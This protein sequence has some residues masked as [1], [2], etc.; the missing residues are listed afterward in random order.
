MKKSLILFCFA[1]ASCQSSTEIVSTQSPGVIMPL[2][3]GNIWA[4]QD[5][6]SDG[7]I[8]SSS[9]DTLELLNKFVLGSDTV[10]VS[11]VETYYANRKDGLWAQ[12]FGTNNQILIAKYPG[13]LG[14][15]FGHDSIIFTKQINDT[16]LVAF[17]T[18]K[19]DIIIDS[20]NALVN[21]V[22]GNYTCYKYK[23][24]YYNT[25]HILLFRQNAYYAVNV[26]LIKKESF[27][28]DST[29]LSLKL[30]DTYQLTN[31]ILK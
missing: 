5:L 21:V 30:S 25:Q 13:N 8:S 24:D 6:Q 26:G 29:S 11:Q 16:T 9:D 3:V 1:L 31:V 20:V 23:A 10:F 17:D 14:E 15:I 18:A 4:Y 27:S 7:G 22:A 28:F 12:Y 19:A 2:A